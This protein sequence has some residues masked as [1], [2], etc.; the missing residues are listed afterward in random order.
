M[1]RGQNLWAA[2]TGATPEHW[3]DSVKWFVYTLVGS[4]LPIWGSWLLLPVLSQSVNWSDFVRH[5]EF[6]LYSA[7]FLSPALYLITRDVALAP[8][9]HRQLFAL[10]TIVLIVCSALLFAGVTAATKGSIHG[11]VLDENVLIKV[12]IPLLLLS[13]LVAF[14]VT[15]LDNARL[16]PDVR[17]LAA[18]SEQQLEKDFDKTEGANGGH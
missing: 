1:R 14:V 2:L 9:V 4:L 11:I 5:G 16:R 15:V 6:A 13:S 10:S 8:F 18:A 17:R 7:A 3:N 12:S